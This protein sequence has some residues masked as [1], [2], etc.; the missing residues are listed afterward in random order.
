MEKQT[1]LDELKALVANEDKLS[2]GRDVNELRTRF[3]DFVLEDERKKQ[4]AV[5]EAKENGENVEFE[6]E[7]DPIRNEFYEVYKEFKSAWSLALDSKK[8]IQSENLKQ[9]R[10]LI[11]RLKDLIANEEHIGAAFNAYKEI[12]EAWKLIGEIERE[13]RAEVQAEYSKLLE[14]FFYNMKIYR[15]LK[16]HDFHRNEQVK[17]EVI[18]K[19]KDLASNESLRDIEGLIKTYQNEWDEI[20][21]VNKD[22][23]EAIKESYLEVV[24]SVYE[25]IN[26][27]Y[28]DKRAVQ[29]DNIEKKQILLSKAVELNSTIADVKTIKDWDEKTQELLSIQEYWKQIG[30]G[31]K[32]ENEEVWQLFRTECDSFFARKKAFF[33]E[34]RSG[35]DAIVTQKE[36]II[37]QANQL[38]ESTDWKKTSEQLVALQKKWKNLG[39]AGQ[40]NEQRLW[41]D[42]RSACDAFFN[43]KQGFYDEQDK[44]NETNLVA[45]RELISKIQSYVIAE[46]KQQA[47]ADLKEFTNT[48]NEIGH[49]PMKE[50]DGI[51]TDFKTAI[52]AHYK[53]LKLEGE[54][55]EKVL[56]QSKI[57]T[58]KSSP[59][60]SKLLDREKADLRKQIDTLKQDVIQYENNLGF[61]ANSKGAN[62]LKKEVEKKIEF[63]K[64]KIDEMIRKIKMIPNE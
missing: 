27:F 23:W 30:F 39:N 44:L 64:R 45:K 55:K 48:F 5:L 13:K 19:I 62:D 15:E 35:F 21:P 49:V 42:F 7:D 31:P 52:D 32:K 36:Q 1:F 50:K 41:K 59:N 61:F 57:E 60:A 16:E 6:R 11:A 4:V 2:I 58:L 18:Q 33:D 8:A 51:Y 46:D 20:G 3:D 29:A 38:K 28:E 22:R 12:H 47:L 63:S 53:S 37:A 54:E 56:F 10:S 40:K 14:D 34:L 43:A 26:K 25:R 17:L 24:R 9:K